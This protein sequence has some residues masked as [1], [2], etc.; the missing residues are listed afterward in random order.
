M[1]SGCLAKSGVEVHAVTRADGDLCDPDQVRGLVEKTRPDC[2]I[3]L[4]G[5]DRI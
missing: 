1:H 2:V 3:H 5:G 4:A